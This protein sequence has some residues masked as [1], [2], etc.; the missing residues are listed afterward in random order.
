VSCFNNPDVEAAVGNALVEA[1]VEV[2]SGYVLA[3]W[4]L[5][6]GEDDEWGEVTSVSFTSDDT[7]LTLDCLVSCCLL[8]SGQRCF[9]RLYC[10]TA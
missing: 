5:V 6:N 4:D 10:Y 8:F 7:P 1:G 3:G 9:S 2:Y